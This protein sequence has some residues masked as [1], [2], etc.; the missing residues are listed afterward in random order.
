MAVDGAR[1]GRYLRAARRWVS[2]LLPR[3]RRPAGLRVFYGHDL[4][5]APGEPVVGGTAKSQRLA[6]RFPNSPSD[7][8]LLYLGSTWL[9]RDL[10]PLL[11]LAKRRRVPVVLNQDGVAY[12]G[13][14]G[15]ATG[16]LNAVNR[17][18]LQAADHVIYQSRFSK[19][20]ADLFVGAPAGSWEILYNAVDVERF[21]PAQAAPAA[22]PVLVLAGDQTQEYRL[23]LALRTLA[24]VL[25]F[26]PDATLLVTGRLV[27]PVQPLIEELGLHGRVE[28]VGRYSQRDAPALLRR[29]HLLLH[30]KV[31]DPC[32]SA[33]IE[34]MACGLPVVYPASGGT[35]ELVGD[36]AGIGVAHPDSWERDV[37]PSPE[38]LA[39][40]VAG[41]LAARAD[42]AA[43][44][45]KRAVERFGL[46]PWLDRHGELFSEL[47]LRP[48]SRPS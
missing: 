7:F 41:V 31:K 22:G 8:T 40:A 20:S 36:E 48:R 46:E 19:D 44:A 5:P 29:A 13:W 26:E 47:T 33:V 16:E 9:P 12:P 1:I 37:P 11:R 45:R 42:Y 43:A 30:T 34:A 32:P 2:L 15:E 38:A 3:G 18:V 4:V 39:Q 6:E 21:T 14:A 35:L 28:L 10:D 24:A 17:R 27:S 23:E 25:S